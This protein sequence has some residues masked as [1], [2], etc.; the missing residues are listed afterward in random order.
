MMTILNVLAERVRLTPDRL[1]VSQWC[2]GASLTYQQLM[3]QAQRIGAV[4]CS[5]Y[6][7]GSRVLLLLDNGID[8]VLSFLGCQYGG[9]IPVPVAPPELRLGGAGL[10][11][12]QGIVEQTDPVLVVAAL[13]VIELLQQ[14]AAALALQSAWSHLSQRQRHASSALV[15][16]YPRSAVS[17]LLA[18]TVSQRLPEVTE[19]SVA[20]LQYT[21]GSTNQP[22]GVVLT[23]GNV[24]ANTEALLV[25]VPA[26]E[27]VLTWLP[28]Y[29]D[30][31]LMCG[32]FFPLCYGIPV[33]LMRPV[34][35]MLQPLSWLAG[36]A[37]LPASISAAPN[38]A[39]ALCS[40]RLSRR[41]G[42]HHIKDLSNWRCSIVA[43]EPVRAETLRQF[44][45]DFKP[46]GFC[47]SI[48]TVGYGLAENTLGVSMAKLDQTF[49]SVTLFCPRALA[50]GQA[51]LSTAPNA[52]ELVAH[53]AGLV[54]HA[55]QIV[56]P[57]TRKPCLPNQ[58]GEVWVRGPS[59][60]QGYW[61][62][63][64]EVAPFSAY[65][66][67]N[68]GP[69]LRT[70]DLG[71]LYAGQLYPAG[72]LKEV[73]IIRG[74]NFQVSELAWSV[75]RSHSAIRMSGVSV[76]GCGT[77]VVVLAELHVGKADPQGI[78]Q[79][80]RAVL[81][82]DFGVKLTECVLLPGKSLAK[83]SSGKL[84]HGVNQARWQ[85]Q[86]LA[87]L[88]V[89]AEGQALRALASPAQLSRYFESNQQGGQCE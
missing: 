37:E 50:A 74:Q 19:S 82:V 64:G 6:P 11:R 61:H 67:A 83:T 3:T 65:T 57:H 35:F 9:M 76:W 56:D 41:R 45:A 26:L 60:G 71:F 51:E 72:R 39:Y 54:G 23:Q 75:A 52:R 81:Q 63:D 85:A 4:L 32:V 77:G 30:Y 38:F 48:L 53:G 13:P 69:F 16:D 47:P 17:D 66:A 43:A 68:Q 84:R 2:D 89:Q 55:F 80:V 20:L 12:V 34:E 15:T 36:L 40:E 78:I 58:V 22:R 1:A 21:S 5:R 42:R 88:V 46:L 8:F 28:M 73:V 29:H 59:V 33:Y 70:G 86:Q 14:P 7:E 18:I 24:I 10:V 79:A 87:A 49:S 31:G 62:G 44:T 27:T 25:E